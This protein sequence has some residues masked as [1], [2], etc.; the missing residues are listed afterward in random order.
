MRRV[1]TPSRAIRAKRDIR[2]LDVNQERQ[3]RDALD[4]RRDAPGRHVISCDTRRRV[5]KLNQTV[6]TKSRSALASATR[7]A[8]FSAS[9]ITLGATITKSSGSLSGSL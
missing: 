2:R 1:G 7:A 5:E 9:V 8:R 4:R 6:L 3:R